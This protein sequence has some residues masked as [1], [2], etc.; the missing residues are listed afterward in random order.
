M[1]R[2]RRVAVIGLSLAV[3]GAAAHVRAQAPAASPVR[4]VAFLKASNPQVGAHFG[5]GGT[6]DGHAG[7]GVAISSRLDGRCVST[8][9][10]SSPMRFASHAAKTCDAAFSIRAAKKSIASSRWE[11]P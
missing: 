3:A 2:T 4:Q 8:I 1:R 10:F 9:V 6:L 11:N 5:C 7:V